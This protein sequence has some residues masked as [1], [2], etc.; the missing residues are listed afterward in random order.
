VSLTTLVLVGLLAGF[1]LGAAAASGS[2]AL[3]ALAPA[4]RPL[5]TL[6]VTGVLMT[7]APL[8]VASLI[9]SV[10]S[11]AVSRLVD[12]A[13]WRAILLLAFLLFVVRRDHTKPPPG[14]PR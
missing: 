9:L 14:C 8:V 6:W 1:A 4:M 13:G 10:S 2:P 3:R 11:V 12:G 5:G 7:V